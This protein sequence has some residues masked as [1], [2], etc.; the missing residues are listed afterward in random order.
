MGVTEVVKIG[1]PR[2]RPLILDEKLDGKLRSM[3]TSLRLASA[4]INIHVVAGVLN[5]FIRA[6]RIGLVRIWTL[7]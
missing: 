5:G 2:G 7:K 6:N 3:I 4:G 1:K